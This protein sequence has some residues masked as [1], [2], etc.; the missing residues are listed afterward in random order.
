MVVRAIKVHLHMIVTVRVLIEED[1]VN[2]WHQFIVN[3]I[4]DKIKSLIWMKFLA[5]CDSN[6]CKNAG[7]CSDIG[8]RYICTC[9]PGYTG[10][11]CELDIRPGKC[12]Y[13]LIV[14]YFVYYL[15]V[16]ELDCSPGYCF[17]NTAGPHAFACYCMDKTVHL[18]TCRS[19]QGQVP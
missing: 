13:E 4:L 5:S 1:N 12:I 2:L 7:T 11:T 9:L 3:S 17:A 19:R 16:C 15:A 18:K 6:P 10:N 8:N 14:M